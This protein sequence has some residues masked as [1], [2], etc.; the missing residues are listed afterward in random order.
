[1]Q[2]H[3]ETLFKLDGGRLL[4]TNEREERPAP[5]F[6]LGRTA[7][8]NVWRVRH[9]VSR[10][11]AAELSV[12][13]EAEAF[14]GRSDRHPRSRQEYERI[15]SREEE[16]RRT[17]SG[18]AYRFPEQLPD[19]GSTRLLTPDDADLLTSRFDDWR[20]DLEA[21]APVI[22]AL[23]RGRPV[24]LCCSVRISVTAHEAGVETP[25]EFRGKGYAGRVVSA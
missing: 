6:F 24:S 13:A 7:H 15:L 17:W 20:P 18:P 21:G 23:E 3:L 22:V 1:M 14:A 16:V 25:P 2:H 10:P 12:L 19:P 11:T 8:G 9:D 4:A 5:R